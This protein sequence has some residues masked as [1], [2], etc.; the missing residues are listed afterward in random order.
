MTRPG[1]D[2]LSHLTRAE[3]DRLNTEVPSRNPT[4]T[5]FQQVMEANHEV[6]MAARTFNEGRFR[7]AVQS[8]EELS[9]RMDDGDT[10][11]DEVLSST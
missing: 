8:L 3:L 9:H 7:R 10:D 2:F 5:W 1:P 4:K 6:E 11:D